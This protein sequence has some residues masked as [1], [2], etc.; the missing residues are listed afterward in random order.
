MALNVEN[1]SS[2][3]KKMIT[4]KRPHSSQKSNQTNGLVL[5]VS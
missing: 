1:S 4:T 3:S 5:N 2:R